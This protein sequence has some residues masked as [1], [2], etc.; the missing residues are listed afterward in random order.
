[1]TPDGMFYWK[2]G[3]SWRYVEDDTSGGW[4]GWAGLYDTTAAGNDNP[5][6]KEDLFLE[7]KNDIVPYIKAIDEYYMPLVWDT[8]YAVS[9]NET[10]VGQTIKSIRAVPNHPDSISPDTGWFHVGEYYDNAGMRYFMLVNRACSQGVDDPAEAGSITAIVELNRSALS[11]PTQL[12]VI[13]IADSI[14]ADWAAV[15]ETTYTSLYDDKLY[16]TTVLKAGEGRLFKIQTLGNPRSL[17]DYDVCQGEYHYNSTVTISSSDTISFKCPSILTFPQHDTLIINGGLFTTGCDTGDSL[18]LVAFAAET[19][20]VS[21]KGLL[22][23]GSSA[24]GELHYC[25]IDDVDTLGYNITIDDSAYVDIRNSTIKGTKSGIK[26][27]S[28]GKLKTENCIFQDGKS[29]IYNSSGDSLWVSDCEFSDYVE[30]GLKSENGFVEVSNCDFVDIETYGMEI[31][32]TRLS[33]SYCNFD[34]IE[35]YGIYTDS[36]KSVIDNCDFTW[37]EDYAIYIDGHLS[38]SNDSNEITNCSLQTAEDSVLTGSQY[39]I[40]VDDNNSIRISDNQI[41]NYE[42]GDIKLSNSNADVI[43]DSIVNCTNYGIYA[44]NSDADIKDCIIDTVNTGI[45]CNGVHRFRI[46]TITI[47]ITFDMILQIT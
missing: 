38:G 28:S 37:C 34:S 3:S 29:G 40:R 16:F 36:S 11:N 33:A 43:G 10:I 32:D 23:S 2:H 7:F 15:S 47:I 20:T 45:Y 17:T 5:P 46:K 31:S 1:M 24:V 42:Q 12:L 8:T 4:T 22:F 9:P 13:D 30:A 27:S 44:Y 41:K 18:G 39:G 25:R 21:W 6:L 35:N 26:I 19:T 14:T